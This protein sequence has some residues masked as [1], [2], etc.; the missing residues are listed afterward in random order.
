MSFW[1]YDGVGGKV[2]AELNGYGVAIPV[3]NF[4]NIGN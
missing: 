3:V 2:C 4:L 1:V